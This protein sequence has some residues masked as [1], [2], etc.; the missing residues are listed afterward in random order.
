MTISLFFTNKG[1]HPQLTFSLWDISSH[2]AHKVA[3]DL[4]SLHQFLHE[5]IDT[6][7]KAYAKHAD[8]KQEDT[9]D[10]APSTQ[11][12]LNRRNLQMQHPSLKLDH[13]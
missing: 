5:E 8:A 12:W 10:W 3:Q 7:N 9:P 2:I 11:V 13:K 6:A 1:Y 4:W